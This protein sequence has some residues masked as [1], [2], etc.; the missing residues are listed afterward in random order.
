MLYTELTLSSHSARNWMMLGKLSLCVSSRPSRLYR[1]VT[2]KL[3]TSCGNNRNY[4]TNIHSSLNNRSVSS[5]RKMHN[6]F[7]SCNTDFP[8]SNIYISSINSSINNQFTISNNFSSSSNSNSGNVNSNIWYLKTSY[9][10]G[11]LLD[12][13]MYP[14]TKVKIMVFKIS[15]GTFFPLRVYWWFTLCRQRSQIRNNENKYVGFQVSANTGSYNIHTWFTYDKAHPVQYSW[16]LLSIVLV[17][18]C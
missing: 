9:R 13:K 4:Y 10:K 18:T 16:V 1:T 6:I 2:E 14:Y 15:F 3:C 5:N 8:R 12:V 7:Q 17:V 11:G